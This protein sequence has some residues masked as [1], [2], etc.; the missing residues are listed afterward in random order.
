LLASKSLAINFGSLLLL[1]SCLEHAWNSRIHSNVDKSSPPPWSIKTLTL[2]GDPAH[3]RLVDTDPL[4]AFLG[5][6]SHIIFLSPTRLQFGDILLPRNIARSRYNIFKRMSR[7]TFPWASLESLQFVSLTLPHITLRLTA[8]VEMRTFTVPMD[9]LSESI[10]WAQE[11]SDAYGQRGEGRVSFADVRATLSSSIRTGVH[12]SL[13]WEQ[14]W[15][16][17]LHT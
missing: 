1:D 15:A 5:S 14:A 16:Y 4:Y 9:Q 11:I 10:H 7:C 12:A 8:R 13:H 3:Y 6:I 2:W 17:G